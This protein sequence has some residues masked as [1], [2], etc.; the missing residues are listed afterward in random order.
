MTM[1]STNE[2]KPINMLKSEFKLLG[3]LGS[4]GFS[5]VYLVE[6]LEKKGEMFAAKFQV[7]FEISLP[8]VA[9]FYCRTLEIMI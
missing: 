5:N 7:F 4:G 8:I 2:V 9:N 1:K 6:S 3:K